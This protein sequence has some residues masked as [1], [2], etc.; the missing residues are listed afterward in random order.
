MILGK[1]LAI[2]YRRNPFFNR[3]RRWWSRNLIRNLTL[4]IVAH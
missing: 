3:S 4:P 1:K 2:N